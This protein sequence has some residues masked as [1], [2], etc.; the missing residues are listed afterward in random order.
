MPFKVSTPLPNREGLGESLPLPRTIVLIRLLR[1]LRHLFPA[2][3]LPFAQ[4]LEF[5][6]ALRWRHGFCEED[7]V[8]VHEVF[9]LPA[10]GEDHPL[11][12]LGTRV[13]LQLKD[14]GHAHLV[15]QNRPA[16]HALAYQVPA[17]AGRPLQ[18]HQPYLVLLRQ[19]QLLRGL[20][21]RCVIAVHIVE[22]EAALALATRQR[23]LG[24]ADVV[25][26]L[27]QLRL[28]RAV[29]LASLGQ[30][31]QVR[32]R[33]P[34]SHQPG[35]GPDGAGHFSHGPV[36]LVFVRNLIYHT[37]YPF[38]VNVSLTSSPQGPRPYGRGAQ[39]AGG[40]SKPAPSPSPPR[41]APPWLSRGRARR[42]ARRGRSPWAGSRRP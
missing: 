2:R 16:L 22:E 18:H 3:P 28:R 26:Q 17:A 15:L 12:V 1:P 5:G 4:P 35:T 30:V 25:G 13:H 14:G 33:V 19:Y 34:E 6:F 41:S 21:L 29:A 7:V 20:R 11:Q 27:H 36:P 24:I 38:F 31:P 10:G 23:T 9:G 8:Q 39:R 32:L 42:T 37:F 40:G